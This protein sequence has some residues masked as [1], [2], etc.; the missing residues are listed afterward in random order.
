MDVFPLISNAPFTELEAG[1][2]YSIILMADISNVD[3]TIASNFQQVSAEKGIPTISSFLQ[4]TNRDCG[5]SDQVI[6]QQNNSM[7]LATAPNGGNS[8]CLRSVQLQ[9]ITTK[10]NQAFTAIGY[11]AITGTQS[12]TQMIYQYITYGSNIVSG[13]NTN[14]WLDQQMYIG[15]GCWGGMDIDPYTGPTI[16]VIHDPTGPG[17]VI[18]D[19]VI[20]PIIPLFPS[21]TDPMRNRPDLSNP[22]IVFHRRRKDANPAGSTT[23]FVLSIIYLIFIILIVVAIGVFFVHALVK[24]DE[25]EL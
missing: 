17:P 1:V 24:K 16:P 12:C 3:A 18:P 11:P 22:F 6:T 13:H 10:V 15:L 2:S 21:P 19:P 14:A 9:S 23:T 20:P 5:W 25:P 8:Y 7:C 4:G